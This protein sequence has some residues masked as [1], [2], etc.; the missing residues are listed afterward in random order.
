VPEAGFAP[1]LRLA[2]SVVS[3]GA[4]AIHFS[5]FG[6]H[7][8][9]YVP[10][11]LFFAAVAWFQAMWAVG[12]VAVPSRWVLNGG[13]QGSLVVVAVWVVSRTWGVPLG[14]EAGR[15]EPASSLDLA[16]T[17]LEAL[18]VAGCA[19]LVRARARDTPGRLTGPGA[20]GAAGV[21]T[22]L[23]V[24]VVTA[25]LPAPHPHQAPSSHG[26]SHHHVSAQGEPDPAQIELVRTAMNRYQDIDVAR[27]E[28]WDQEH[29]DTPE[30]GAHFARDGDEAE[31]SDVRS[32][33]DL[34][35]P[36][37][38]MYSQLGRDAWQLVAV[39]YVVDQAGSPDPPTDIHGAAFHEHAWTCVVAGE[40]LDE[41]DVGV[42][43]RDECRERHGT[44]S[45]GAVWMT[46]VWLIDNPAGVFAETNPDLV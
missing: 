35:A 15:P 36:D 19:I 6:E 3:L 7:F 44:W 22:V 2:L 8:R 38:L 23:A 16:A 9:D 27:A 10:F 43:S 14:P 24:V 12:I 32:G 29:P 26:G 31:S 40:E 41:D 13:L 46:H 34:A 11:G 30:I 39:A 45:P 20:A 21:A 33:I 28:G 42:I 18:I 17:A 37:L 4:A 25:V 5:V 1:Q